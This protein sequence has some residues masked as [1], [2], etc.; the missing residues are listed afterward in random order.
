[1][2]KILETQMELPHPVALVLNYAALDFNF[3]SWMTPKN[4]RVLQ[5]E[6]S[7]V[8]LSM[9]AEQK[10]HLRHISPLS[11][12]GDRKLPRR[13]RS[14]RDTLRT[15]TSS[16][17]TPQMPALR[18]SHTTTSIRHVGRLDEDSSDDEGGAMGDVEDEVFSR[19]N[20]EDKPLRARIRFNPQVSHVEI[21]RAPATPELPG[22]FDPP[23]PGERAPLGTRLTM[24][25]RTG[26]FQDRIISPS[27]VRSFSPPRSDPGMAAW[28]DTAV[29]THT[30]HRL[31]PLRSPV[32][33]LNGE[34]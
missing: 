17:A 14:L 10:D 1:M 25:S 9:L 32:A 33:L 3:T 18:A 11:M 34:C 16:S 23:T 6:Q 26:Y 30:R 15:L 19:V 5:T 24:T 29:Q 13:R 2:F 27:M 7:A 20:E 12:V 31:L 4:L 22:L 21:E 28:G 8:H